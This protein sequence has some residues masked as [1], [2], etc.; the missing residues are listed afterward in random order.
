MEQISERIKQESSYPW[1]KRRRRGRNN[2]QKTCTQPSKLVLD[3]NILI[4]AFFWKGN[5]NKILSLG[6]EGKITLFS[7]QEIVNELKNSILRDFDVLEENLLKKING[8]LESI[9]LV[10]PT[11]IVDVCEDVDDNKVIEAAIE[12][13]ANFIVSGDKHLLKLKEFEG[14]SILT[15][16]EFLDLICHK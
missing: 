13:K 15:A 8:L 2:S 9:K 1:D 5:P 7:S 12:A 14:I 16:K 11:K 10:I 3:T 4:S 6:L